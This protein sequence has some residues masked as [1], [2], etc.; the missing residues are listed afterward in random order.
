MYFRWSL[1]KLIFNINK[2]LFIFIDRISEKL[3]EKCLTRLL[4]HHVPVE[5]LLYSKCFHKDYE[6]FLQFIDIKDFYS[7]MYDRILF[8]SYATCQYS[9]YSKDILTTKE[10]QKC[11]QYFFDDNQT[12]FYE[13]LPK[14]IDCEKNKGRKAILNSYMLMKELKEVEDNE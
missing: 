6:K 8:T 1:S 9:P 11:I 4:K 10:Y 14:I 12:T 3:Y 5:I 13:L 7:K 2:R